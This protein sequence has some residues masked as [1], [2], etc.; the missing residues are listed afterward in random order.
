[1]LN[2]HEPY[3]K[4]ILLYIYRLLP[5]PPCQAPVSGLLPKGLAR[6]LI[7]LGDH[8][9]ALSCEC[10]AIET[11]RIQSSLAEDAPAPHVIFRI[12]GMT[13]C[14]RDRKRLSCLQREASNSMCASY[15]MCHVS[16]RAL[17]EVPK[18]CILRCPPPFM[19]CGTTS[20]P[21][22]V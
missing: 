21:Q 16:L 14:A 9:L 10:I 4:A 5:R 20:T 22:T 17:Q 18:V 19:R 1:M 12:R 8:A 13:I 7:S 6:C 3:Q 15:G 11:Y 2:G